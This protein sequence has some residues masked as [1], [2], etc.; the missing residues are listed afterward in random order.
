MSGLLRALTAAVALVVVLTGCSSG[1]ADPGAETPAAAPSSES[2]AAEEPAPDPGSRPRVGECHA[3]TFRQ[4]V[5]VAGR[6]APVPCRRPHT[7]ET[8]FVGRL[9]LDTKAGHTR[10]PDSRAAQAQAR[11]A[12]TTRLPRHLG[13][14]PR[15]LRLSMAQA[16]WFTPS[17]AR[18][19][20]GAD[21]F[22][23]DVVVVAAPRTL[24]RLPRRTKGWS[25][26]PGTAMC[27]TAAP[28]SK[29]FRRVTCQSPHSWVAVATVD[30]PGTR[31]PKEAVIA[32]RMEAPC[33]DA[34]RTRAGDPLDLTWS[35]E[36]PTADQ[37]SAG[38]RYGICWAPA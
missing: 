23:C 14:D 17:P 28:G 22:R 37:W 16:V 10:R 2:T 35:Q 20:A 18:A 6:T 32:D 7:A 4:A 31:L 9:D 8:F 5:T 33:R 13:R 3:L 24:L 36:S 30:I 21:W 15:D 27:A 11:R 12:C 26:A 29:G 19:E 38:R 1:D 34:A 25:E